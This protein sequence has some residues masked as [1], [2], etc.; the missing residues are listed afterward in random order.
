MTFTFKNELNR[1]ERGASQHTTL[2][3]W[4]R[5]FAGEW[6]I[7]LGGRKGRTRNKTCNQQY[8]IDNNVRLTPPSS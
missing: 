4:D 5:S 1:F 6:K 7:Q 2:T 8:E 3:M